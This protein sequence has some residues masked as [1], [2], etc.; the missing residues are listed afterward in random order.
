MDDKTQTRVLEWLKRA[1]VN[2]RA[3]RHE[4]EGEFYARSISTAYYVMFYAATGALTSIGV[5]RAK[6]SGIISA[7]GEYFARTGKV[8]RELGQILNRAMRDREESDYD[9]IPEANHDL[10]QKRLDEAER[11]VREID[12]YLESQGLVDA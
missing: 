4:F 10:A 6:H 5:D 3:A 1:K 9:M 8:S 12:T 2:L 7:F 11:F